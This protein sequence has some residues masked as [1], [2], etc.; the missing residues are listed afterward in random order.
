M[1]ARMKRALPL[2][3]APALL[4]AAAPAVPQASDPESP[5]RQERAEP[6]GSRLNLK[7]EDPAHSRPRITFGERDGGGEAAARTLPTL[8]GPSISFDR[9]SGL[10]PGSRS[11]PFP[12]DTQLDR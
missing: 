6:R 5:P 3:V 10:Q 2:F 12:E 8:G 1:V 11:S 4:A 7:L 9:P